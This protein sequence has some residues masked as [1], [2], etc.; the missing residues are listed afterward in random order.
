MWLVFY[1]AGF[2]A[3]LLTAAIASLIASG[4]AGKAKSAKV[5]WGVF[6]AFIAL[7]VGDAALSSVYFK[8]LCV[9]QGGA[10]ISKRF[11]KVEGYLLEGQAYIPDD[12]LLKS[13]YEYIEARQG[14]IKRYTKTGDGAVTVRNV[15]AP[16][17]L[18]KVQY[19][20]EEYPFNIG[21]TELQIVA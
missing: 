6:A 10:E 18:F 2:A 9:A 1:L 11:D 3:Y 17:S 20:H 7:P 12:M 5:G 8:V 19:V 16:K 21:K 13:P 15:A 4:F 14:K